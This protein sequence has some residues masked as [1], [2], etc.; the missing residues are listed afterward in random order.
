MARQEPRPP[1]SVA[2]EGR[3]K[4][5]VRHGGRR[6]WRNAVLLSIFMQVIKLRVFISGVTGFI[7]S[8]L[9]ELLLRSGDQVLG[10]TAQ[11]K[12][13]KNVPDTLPAAVKLLTWDVTNPA[14]QAVAVTI[15]EFAP[16]VFFHLA[17]MSI[18]RECGRGVPSPQAVSVNVV[19]TSHVLDLVHR[20]T[21]R[22]RF[23][24]ASTSHVY[25][26]TSSSAPMVNEH[27]RIEPL[28]AYGKTKHRAEQDIAGRIQRSG[29]DACIVRG[30]HHI[31]PRQPPG[32]ML[33]DWLAQLGEASNHVLH[34]RCLNSYLD[35][36]DV[37]DA[38][39]AYRLLAERGIS[40]EIYNL[41]SGII[42]RSGDVL[43]TI[44]AMMGR[45]FRIIEAS[46]A[47]QWNAIANIQKL[48]SLGWRPN[49]DY[50][51][52]LADMIPG[53]LNTR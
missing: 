4:F 17:G 48:R 53:M 44:I 35:L 1:E 37:R 10:A 9:A 43:D 42:R 27:A 16:D 51:R 5:F 41:G 33:T 25:A 39:R 28:T 12:W 47:E 13:R 18:P 31:G 40:G 14:P 15:S 50:E 46:T 34:V 6:G 11:G 20:V 3:A 22:P 49:L 7:G 32:L 24:F 52:S 2:A 38:S 45:K 26:R 23:I 30:F 29:L 8:H 21:S 36:I 19:G